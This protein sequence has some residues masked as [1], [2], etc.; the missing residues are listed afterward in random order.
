MNRTCIQFQDGKILNQKYN[1]TMIPINPIE[2]ITA[3]WALSEA[4][5]G[6]VLHALRIPFTGL[7]IGGS[8]VIFITLIPFFNYKRGIILRATLLVMTVKAIVSP[9]SPINAY[10]AVAFQGIIGE[11]LFLLIPSK[12]IAAFLLGFLSLLESSV[13][14]L[15]VITII[16]GQNVWE[17]IDLFS[18]YILNQFLIG[19]N[20]AESISVSM[21][22]IS[23]Y[24]CIHLSAGILIGI[25]APILASN[26]RMKIQDESAQKLPAIKS[27]SEIIEKSNKNR[28]IW[29]K[30]SIISIILL[31]TTIFILSYF[32][33]VFEK[34]KGYEAILMIFR[35]IMI[36]GIWYYIIGP[37]LLKYLRHFL[38]K[39]SNKYQSEIND[40]INIFPILKQVIS[41]TW[42]NTKDVRK[43]QRVPRFIEGILIYLLILDFY[44]L[45]KS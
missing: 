32:F 4:A 45:P 11:T 31:A 2:R 20:S 36:I 15:L 22:I 35:S 42:A 19:Q 17:A 13:Q 29:K 23:I 16:F 27:L 8:A 28:K 25:W 18:E 37:F 44:K 12:K 7:F 14:K 39:K 30:F 1:D 26:V 6:G 24:M 43:L 33:P 5:L 10:L 34:S 40:I 3:L 21:I 9:H 41:Q 38:D